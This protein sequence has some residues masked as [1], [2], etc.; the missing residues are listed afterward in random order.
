[1]SPSETSPPVAPTAPPPVVPPAVDPARRAAP[2]PPLR[3]PDEP[4][5]AGDASAAG[6]PPRPPG[7]ALVRRRARGPW[8][9][10]WRW[11]LTLLLFGLLAAAVVGGGLLAAVYRQARLEQARP[12]AAI[13]VLG[14]AQ[15]NGVPGPTL[16]A[17]LDHALALWQQGLAP[18][19]V[20]TG[21]RQPGDQFTEAEAGQ[22][23]LLEQGVP[24]GAILL[25]NEGHD[26]WQS[27]Q[28]VA[29]I[30]AERG[31]PD[32]PLL[33]VSDGFHLLRLKL[34]ARELGLTAYGSPAPGSPIRPGGG[35]EFSY[36]V[37]EVGAILAHLAGRA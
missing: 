9:E 25:E 22:R 2:A 12:A 7:P 8:S 37:R 17:R 31:Q 36:A 23:W 27:M 32:A 16:Q 18:T 5:A 26:S 1:M 11:L 15:F 21:G 30:M 34:M 35:A 4:R 10:A 20:L 19:V 14:T 33:L 29:R 24:P 28:G 13:V 3:L 6:G